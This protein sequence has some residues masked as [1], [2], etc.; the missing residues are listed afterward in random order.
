MA[1]ISKINELSPHRNGWTIRVRVLKKWSEMIDGGGDILR[2]LLVD[3]HLHE[4]DWKIITGFTVELS[5]PGFRFAM[6]HHT[7]IFTGNTNLQRSWGVITDHYMSFKNFRSIM[8]GVYTS[9]YPIDLLGYLD[10]V[11][12]IEVVTDHTFTLGD[13]M[14]TSR[15]T[16]TIKDLE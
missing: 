12:E 15:V 13:N 14:Q 5:P 3:D 16:F 6:N 4:G 1:T 10:G 2:F 11:G 9:N 8:N 7:I